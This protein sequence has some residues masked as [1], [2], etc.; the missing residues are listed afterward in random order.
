MGFDSLA[1]VALIQGVHTQRMQESIDF[2]AAVV[3]HLCCQD[4]EDAGRLWIDCSVTGTE[5]YHAF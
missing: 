1:A 5:P 2:I 4:R 3:G